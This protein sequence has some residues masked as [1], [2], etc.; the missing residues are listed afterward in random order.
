MSKGFR[1]I[2]VAMLAILPAVVLAATEPL[3]VT[4]RASTDRGDRETGVVVVSVTN[5]SNRPL[6]ILMADSALFTDSDKLM[7]DVMVVT[8]SDGAAVAYEG[9]ASR[10][11]V[12][13]RRAYLVLEPGETKSSRVDLPANYAVDGGSYTV[14]YVQRYIEEEEFSPDGATAHEVRSNPLVLYVN[15]SLIQGNRALKTSST[16]TAVPVPGAAAGTPFVHQRINRETD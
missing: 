13:E 14:S 9:R 8:A 1:C 15:A 10:P 7:N 3:G 11:A 16:A 5:Q 12:G 6:L 4:V 2:A